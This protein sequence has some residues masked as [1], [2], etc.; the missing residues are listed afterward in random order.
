MNQAIYPNR[1]QSIFLILFFLLSFGLYFFLTGFVPQLFGFQLSSL[2]RTLIYSFA[3]PIGTLPIILY[4]SKK[5]GVQIKKSIEL[6]NIRI[7]LLLLLLAICSIIITSPLSNPKEYLNNLIDGKLKFMFFTKTEFELN[8]VIKILGASV[9]APIFEEILFRKQILGQLLKKHS[10]ILSIV[11]SSLLFAAGHLRYNDIGTL[12]IWGLLLGIV[13]YQT[14][15]LETAILFHSFI[16][17]STFFIRKEFID[18]TGF[19]LIKYVSI[20]A[21]CFTVMIIIIKYFNRDGEREREIEA[22]IP[23]TE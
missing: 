15:S 19:Q 6:C 12:F 14:N 20:M 2:Y 21:V 23:D 22:E 17:L 9:F 8:I 5:S 16:G 18:F 11:L 4:I 3:S 10:P 13:Y 7:M 1:K